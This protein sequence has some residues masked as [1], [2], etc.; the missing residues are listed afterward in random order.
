MH[1]SLC[2]LH[3]TLHAAG[4]GFDQIICAVCKSQTIQ[5]L[6]DA[7]PEG[8]S[9]QSVEMTL[10]HQVLSGRELYVDAL[11]LGHHTNSAPN[12]VRLSH[13]IKARDT[14]LSTG[15]NH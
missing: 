8:S 11:C 10:V 4:E 2:Q 1:E 3:P 9:A 12:L 7:L 13:R 15:G 14:R 5:H 6:G